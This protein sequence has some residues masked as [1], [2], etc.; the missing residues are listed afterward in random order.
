MGGFF[1]VLDEARVLYVPAVFVRRD[2]VTAVVER[3][4]V[5]RL[6]LIIRDL[7]GNLLPR[8]LPCSFLV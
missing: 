8:Q 1:G 5:K 2:Q 7:N 4:L 3:D 6:G